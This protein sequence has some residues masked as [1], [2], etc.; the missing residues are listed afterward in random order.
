VTAAQKKRA[1][2]SARFEKMAELSLGKR[3]E[4]HRVSSE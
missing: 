2:A 3:G 4:C 1:G